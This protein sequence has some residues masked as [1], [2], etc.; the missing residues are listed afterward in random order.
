[1]PVVRVHDVGF[2]RTQVLEDRAA[3]EC[4]PLVVIGSAVHAIPREQLRMIHKD[5]AHAVAHRRNVRSPDASRA[6]RDRTR[7]SLRRDAEA[8]TVDRG[9]QRKVERDVVSQSGEGLRQAA[10]DV[11]EAADLRVG[12]SL[13]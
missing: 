2:G 8:R 5:D 7:R 13:G 4:V 10:G 11:G 3:E 1:M 6:E 12:S 9:V